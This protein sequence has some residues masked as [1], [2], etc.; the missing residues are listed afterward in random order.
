MEIHHVSGKEMMITDS[1]LR[2]NELPVYTVLKDTAEFSLSVFAVEGAHAESTMTGEHDHE[3]NEQAG[4][5]NEE[6]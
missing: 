2:I 6:P 3:H 5:P 1:L 4:G